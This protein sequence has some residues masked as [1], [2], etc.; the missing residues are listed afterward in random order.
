MSQEDLDTSIP[1]W[2]WDA[3]D[4]IDNKEDKTFLVS[5]M[6]DRAVSMAGTDKVL[7]ITKDTIRK[8]EAQEKFSERQ[9]MK[10]I[11]SR[12]SS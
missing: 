8:K 3:L 7:T 10:K 5:M 12:R 9:K 1:F 4:R 11:S 6:A 2:P